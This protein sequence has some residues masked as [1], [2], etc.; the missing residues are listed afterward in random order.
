LPLSEIIK[1][2]VTKDIVAKVCN[3]IDLSEYKREQA[4]PGL[5]LT[6]RSFGYGWRM[7]IAQR[8]KETI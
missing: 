3:M 7:P 1:I 5:K 4:A 8:Y 2:G 6:S